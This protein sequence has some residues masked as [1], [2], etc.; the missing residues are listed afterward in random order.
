MKPV[1][2]IYIFMLLAAGCQSKEKTTMPTMDK[3]TQTFCVGRHLIDLPADFALA[4]V[5]AHFLPIGVDDGGPLEVTIEPASVTRAEF[6]TAVEKRRAAIAAFADDTT[7][8]LKDV[9]TLKDD[10]TLFRILLIDVDYS[11]ELHLLKGDRYLSIE[12]KSYHSHFSE[13]E[14]RLAAFADNTELPSAAKEL[15]TGFCL[16][17]V[18]VKGKYDAEYASYNFRSKRHPDLMIG[19]EIDTYARDER[20]TLLQRVNGPDSLLK[21]FDARNKVLREGELTVAG[22]RAQE[23]LS[24]IKLGEHRDKKQFGFALETMRPTPGPTFPHI[25]IDLDTGEHDANGDQQPNSLS[26][27]EAIA[28]WDSIVKTI[29]LRPAARN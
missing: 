13:A 11:S 20:Q 29:R 10:A 27:K 26:D 8:I 28:L 6:L 9:K 19:V 12:T 18:V 16:G 3:E 21:K 5:S 22:M 25:H 24:W 7:D 15:Q 14:A 2:L 1:I 4:G 23:W 17:T